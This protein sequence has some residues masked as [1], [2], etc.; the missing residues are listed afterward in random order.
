MVDYSAVQQAVI[1]GDDER[2]VQLVRKALEQNANP[3]D[4][5]TSGLQAGL[6]IVGEKFS[7]G[8]F[9]V[10]E[11]LLAARAVTRSLDVLQPLLLDSSTITIGRVVIGTV[12]GDIHDIGKN[13][14]SMFLGGAGFEVMDLGT[15]VSAERFVTAVKEYSPDILGM[16]GLLTTTMPSMGATIQALE[17]AGIRCQVKVVVGG[18]PVTQHF[19]DQIGADAYC[20]DGGAAIELCRKLVG[21]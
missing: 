11:M 9:F 7:S 12:A 18:A 3:S 21:K 1:E 14:V 6:I 20:A 4:I 2:T 5:V 13:L 15:S 8:E 17:S 19:A 16:S 10:P